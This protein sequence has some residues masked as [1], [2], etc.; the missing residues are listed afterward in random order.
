[1]KTNIKIVFKDKT[2]RVF[3]ANTFGFEEDGFCHLDFVD[4]EDR[5]SL[6]AYASMSEIKYLMFVEVEE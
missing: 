3:D 2:E 1:M 4:E 6:V 5:G